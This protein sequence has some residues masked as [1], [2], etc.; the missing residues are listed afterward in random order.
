MNPWGFSYKMEIGIFMALIFGR[1]TAL[2]Q[3]GK[4]TRPTNGSEVRVL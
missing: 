2:C 3:T 1:A 4:M